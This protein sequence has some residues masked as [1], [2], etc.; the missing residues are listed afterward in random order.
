MLYGASGGL[1]VLGIVF[2]TQGETPP[3]RNLLAARRGRTCLRGVAQT[4]QRREGSNPRG[5][6]N[7]RS[8]RPGA[9]GPP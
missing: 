7:L 4:Q 5:S 9:V 6:Q 2:I 3:G 1:I 8:R